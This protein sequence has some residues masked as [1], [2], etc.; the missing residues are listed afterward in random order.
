MLKEVTIHFV[1]KILRFAFILFWR[2][3][4]PGSMN[5]LSASHS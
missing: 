4:L 2:G 5:S 3:K 1:L